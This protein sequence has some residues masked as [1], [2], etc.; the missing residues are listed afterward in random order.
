MIGFRCAGTLSNFRYWPGRCSLSPTAGEDW[1]EGAFRSIPPPTWLRNDGRP[2]QDAA[3]NQVIRILAGPDIYTPRQRRIW[4]HLDVNN[5]P[6]R[7]SDAEYLD[8]LS[9]KVF[10]SG[11]AGP[12]VKARWPRIREVFYAFDPGT[13]AEMP[14]LLIEHVQEDPGVIRNKRKIRATVENASE[15][16]R[17]REEFGSF[18]DYLRS[19]DDLPYERRAR[20]IS[21]RFKSVGPNTVYYFLADAG[22][23]VPEL[24]PAG[25]K[26][27]R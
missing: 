24:K 21:R 9:H 7:H 17:I 1:G 16:L 6:P 22:E 11:F 2:A 12:P 23:P 26:S 27:R 20:D 3:A 10:I 5:A 18:H 4:H 13:V 19:L 8:N 15:F 14:G 25:V